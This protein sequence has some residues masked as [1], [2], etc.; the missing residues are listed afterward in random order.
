MIRRAFFVV[1]AALAVT[2][3]TIQAG[4]TPTR[5]RVGMVI[6]QRDRKSVV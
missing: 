5:A 4:S 6:T 1:L 2:S 3:L